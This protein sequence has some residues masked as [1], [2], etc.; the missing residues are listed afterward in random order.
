MLHPGY[1]DTELAALDPYR[2]PRE[3][4]L[5][6]LISPEWRERLAANEIRLVSFAEL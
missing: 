6:A 5:A 4:E 1:D 3:R 2:A